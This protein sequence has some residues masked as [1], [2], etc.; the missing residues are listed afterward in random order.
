MRSGDSFIPGKYSSERDV[1]VVDGPGGKKPIIEMNGTLAELTTKTKTTNEEDDEAPFLLLDLATKTHV[2]VER[3]DADLSM[4]HLLELTTKTD[5]RTE[6][7]DDDGP[8]FD[9]ETTEHHTPSQARG[10]M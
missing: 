1:W 9:Y 3:D 4:N 8:F 5:A 2:Q 10:T 7:D 6:R